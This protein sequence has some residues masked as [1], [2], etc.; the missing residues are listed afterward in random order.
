M[1]PRGEGRVLERRDGDR[2]VGRGDHGP[3]ALED[4]DLAARSRPRRGGRATRASSSAD[5]S[6]SS[7]GIAPAAGSEPGELAGVRRQHG[8][9]VVALPP[10]VHRRQR[11]QRLGVEHDRRRR[12]SRRPPGA[13]AGRAR[14]WPGPGRRPG[15]TTIASCSWS[16]IRARAGSGSTSSTSSSGSA[17]VVASTTL[18]ANSGWSDSGTASVTSPAPARPGR[19]ADEQRRA[20][21]VERAGD[22]EQLAER[23]LVAALRALRQ[24]RAATIVVELGGPGRERPA[25]VGA[26]ARRRSIA[27]VRSRPAGAQPRDGS[28]GAAAASS[29]QR[30]GA[31][32]AGPG[33]AAR[34]RRAG[35]RCRA[36]RRTARRRVRIPNAIATA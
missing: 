21:V 18:A 1:P 27:R 33:S 36:G 28:V 7:R 30:R 22:H 15:P 20:G 29:W 10:A 19:P 5:R 2:P 23:A 16:R 8:R 25:A 14:P 35:P 6:P 9:P 34:A 4:D 24:Q 26:A 3:G 12:P 32:R 13:A 11:A 17:I 31:A